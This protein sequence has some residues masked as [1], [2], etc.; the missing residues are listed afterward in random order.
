MANREQLAIIKQAR[1]GQVEAQLT[2]G[3]LYLHGCSGLPQS[4][5]TALH[6]LARAAQQGSRQAWLEIGQNISYEVAQQS[7]QREHLWQWYQLAFDEG[8]M[9]AGLVFARL[10]LNGDAAADLQEQAKSALLAAAKSGLAEAQW[11]LAQQ[12]S[13]LLSSTAPSKEVTDPLLPVNSNTHWVASAAR[14]GVMQAQQALAEAAWSSGNWDVFLEWALPL[15]RALA[16]LN[17]AWH[18]HHTDPSVVH[19]PVLNAEQVSLLTR[20]AHALA[21]TAPEKAD[22]AQV[23]CELAALHGECHAQLQLGLWFA[24]MDEVGVRLHAGLG[25]A[26]FKKAVRWLNLAGEQGLAPA[27]YAL[28]KIFLK[29]EFSQRNVQDAQTY[30]ERAAELGH[31]QAQFECG[32]HAWRNRREIE[33]NDVRALFWLQKA[34]A[35]GELGALSLLEKIAP[36]RSDD[37]WAQSAWRALTREVIHSQPFLAARIEMAALFGLNRAQALLLDIR[38]ADHGHCLVV[39]IRAQYGRSKRH[40][41]LLRSPQQRQALDRISRLFEDVDCGPH[42]PEGNYRQRLYRLK[43]CLPHLADEDDAMLG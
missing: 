42:G 40:L 30:L 16:E 5:S 12:T 19:S 11:L 26:N 36:I 22:E 38:Q 6:W 41:V 31:V 33:G 8:V 3:L 2:L 10:I 21:R 23:F 28:S 32:A 39:D 34:A 17:H 1:A 13:E 29:P 37:T 18:L 15:A 24:R 14:G 4:A 20:C 35:Q 9:V 27:W 7:E 25:S 43:T